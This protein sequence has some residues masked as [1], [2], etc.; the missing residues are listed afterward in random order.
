MIM[1]IVVWFC[2]SKICPIC[3]SL[4]LVKFLKKYLEALKINPLNIIWF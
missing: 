4:R 1:E 3:N 2:D